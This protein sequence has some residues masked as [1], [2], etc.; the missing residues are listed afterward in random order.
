MAKSREKEFTNENVRAFYRLSHPLQKLGDCSARMAEI[1]WFLLYLAQASLCFISIHTHYIHTLPRRHKSLYEKYVN[2]FVH[3]V[4][5]KLLLHYAIWIQQRYQRIIRTN[6]CQIFPCNNIHCT[7]GLAYAVER[8]QL[9]SK[10]FVSYGD[11]M[12]LPSNCHNLIMNG[13]GSYMRSF[14]RGNVDKVILKSAQYQ[15]RTRTCALY[16]LSVL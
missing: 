15:M 8:I 12:L 16:S 7:C 11:E 14:L 1:H 2:L 5:L 3:N 4:I 9:V 6:V 13:E 10:T